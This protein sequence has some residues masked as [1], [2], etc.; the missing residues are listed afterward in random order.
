MSGSPTVS[1]AP[2]SEPGL[3]GSG[4][5]DMDVEANMV[6]SPHQ[7]WF[8][9]GWGLKS[10]RMISLIGAIMAVLNMIFYFTALPVVAQTLLDH[11]TIK[12]LKCQMLNPQKGGSMLPVLGSGEVSKSFRAVNDTE[13]TTRVKRGTGILKWN[14]VYCEPDQGGRVLYVRLDAE[15][16][17][18]IDVPRMMR[19]GW[20]KADEPYISLYKTIEDARKQ[21]NELKK[22]FQLGF[23]G[24]SMLDPLPRASLSKLQDTGAQSFFHNDDAICMKGMNLWVKKALEYRE[25][26]TIECLDDGKVSIFD[27][28]SRKSY[29][30]E[31]TA[32][33][34]RYV[35]GQKV[36]IDRSKSGPE[37]WILQWYEGVVLDVSPKLSTLSSDASAKLRS[38][39]G[40]EV[41]YVGKDEY[42]EAFPKIDSD[43]SQFGSF[44]TEELLPNDGQTSVMWSVEDDNV[45]ADDDRLKTTLGSFD[46]NTNVELAGTGPFTANMSGGYFTVHRQY[47]D[48]QGELQRVPFGIMFMPPFDTSSAKVTLKS[49]LYVTN[50]EEMAT[51]MLPQLAGNEVSWYVE[52]DITLT[53]FA[54]SFDLRLK[55]VMKLPGGAME[56]VT[57]EF[58]PGEEFVPRSGTVNGIKSNNMNTLKI[59]PEV[60]IGDE[61]D[62][63]Q[64]LGMFEF[65]AHKQDDEWRKTKDIHEEVRALKALL[66]VPANMINEEL[67]SIRYDLEDR[68]NSTESRVTRE[69]LKEFVTRALAVETL[70]PATEEGQGFKAYMGVYP[71]EHR[72]LVKYKVN[73]D[74]NAA[75]LFEVKGMTPIL[76]S[77]IP[78]FRAYPTTTVIKDIVSQ[79]QRTPENDDTIRKTLGVNTLGKD[80]TLT[81]FGPVNPFP[82]DFLQF[83]MAQDITLKGAPPEQVGLIKSVQVVQGLTMNKYLTSN[84]QQLWEADPDRTDLDGICPS[85][86][87][88]EEL[89][90]P[91][92]H[93]TV[94]N[95]F[96][97]PV[98]QKNTAFDF[99]LHDPVAFKAHLL[100]E[101]DCRKPTSYFAYSI[102]G[103]KVNYPAAGIGTKTQSVYETSDVVRLDPK[104]Y[105]SFF[106]PNFPREE[107][108]GNKALD[109]GDLCSKASANDMNLTKGI[110]CCF[111]LMTLASACRS[112]PV[113]KQKKFE[114]EELMLIM[115]DEEH[116]EKWKRMTDKKAILKDKRAFAEKHL[117]MDNLSLKGTLDLQLERFIMTKVP[118]SQESAALIG[119]RTLRVDVVPSWLRALDPITDRTCADITPFDRKKQSSP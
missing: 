2:V 77:V 55:Q 29:K 21:K 6:A 15:M 53:I 57:G 35:R 85:D 92:S 28:V 112:K 47:T 3:K 26:T 34:R 10:W 76:R 83:G 71:K 108:G 9:N 100:G 67:D 19:S 13:I 49:K 27:N 97:I 93:I 88:N 79:F 48:R 110:A 45:Y 117:F 84:C 16:K 111:A 114:D 52:G 37:N 113:L 1:T 5:S 96:N 25:A 41:A 105:S 106:G 30:V 44:S 89:Y 115:G 38:L 31:K 59:A 61:N 4:L 39:P 7:G 119:R 70:L 22:P 62:P 56:G 50:Q 11:S 64:G 24:R 73:T 99:T 46:V 68:T 87:S 86:R 54:G 78:N 95:H 60:I 18:K 75:H 116:E 94:I 98:I 17:D 74:P 40:Y 42:E 20:K 63:T 66:M 102:P 58:L 118:Y 101:K 69:D 109:A 23:P 80:Q 33:I 36:W 51:A 8:G 32:L 90:V 12:V 43:S 65:I 91:S 103:I 14:C 104:G 107:P 81:I 72:K 82:F